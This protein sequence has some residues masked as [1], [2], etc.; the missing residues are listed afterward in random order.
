MQMNNLPLVSVIVPVYNVEQYLHRSIDSLLAQTYKNLEILIIDDG[1]TDGSAAICDY[2]ASCDARVRVFHKEN[3]G[4]SDAR[5]M[6]LNNMTGDYVTFVD[7]DDYVES[8]IIE[9]YYNAIKTTGA[10]MV[11]GG[12]H[13]VNHIGKICDTVCINA[14]QILSG[15]DVTKN[16]IRDLYPKNFAW[17]KMYKSSLF[18]VIRFPTGRLYEDT[19]VTYRITAKC[20][21]VCCLP[22]NLYYYEIGRPGNTTSELQSVKAVKSYM[23]GITNCHERLEFIRKRPHYQDVRQIVIRHLHLWALLAIQSACLRG[24]SNYR[25]IQN[26]VSKSVLQ[27]KDKPRIISLRLALSCPLIYY[28]LYS[29]YSKIRKY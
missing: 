22:D 21:H 20:Q 26:Q 27:Y 15:E 9:K 2:Y 12:Y 16:I 14:K 10:E 29:I 13:I 1:S 8:D 18:D 11:V 17:G 19:A 7:S 23:D 24:Y 28:I 5:N 4:Q 3:G 6:A 25:Q